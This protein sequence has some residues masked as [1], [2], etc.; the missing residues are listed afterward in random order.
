MKIDLKN[1][2][3][4]K[5]H[6]AMMNGEY[7]A[8]D[9]A[10]AYLENIKE[11]DRNLLCVTGLSLRETEFYSETGSHILFSFNFFVVAGFILMITLRVSGH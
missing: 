3:I 5:A 4:K 11:K 10:N 6:E 2:S 1:L 9:L 7:T 8:V